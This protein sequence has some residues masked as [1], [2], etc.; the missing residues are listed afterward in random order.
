MKLDSSIS[1]VVTGGASG[2]GEATVRALVA[3]GVKVAI[4]D[5][6]RQ[7]EKGAALEKEL[8]V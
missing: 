1:A 4:F 2:L 5:L 7:A 8:G 6:D 3:R